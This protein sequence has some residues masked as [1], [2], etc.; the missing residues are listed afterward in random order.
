MKKPAFEIPL[1]GALRTMRTFPVILVLVLLSS[2]AM[3]ATTLRPRDGNDYF[4]FHGQFYRAN[5]APSE[6]SFTI[7]VTNSMGV[8]YSVSIPRGACVD[9]GRSCRYRNRE[10]K[11]SKDGVVY[12]RV[13]YDNGGHGNRVWIKSYG[14][15]TN[16]TEAYMTLMI[17]MDGL[18][19]ASF[20]DTFI[21]LGNGGWR[22]HY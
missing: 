3:A 13:L 2:N 10:A 4:F 1:A 17:Y 5:L 15:F 8:V 9:R 12:F 20:S 22:S 19:L 7:E 16:A 6:H 14:E 11:V 18:P 21:R